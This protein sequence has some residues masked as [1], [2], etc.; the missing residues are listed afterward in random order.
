[1]KIHSVTLENIKSIYDRITI[2]FWN[3]LN[4]FIWPNWSWKSN[5][6]DTLNN[7]IHHHFIYSYIEQ[8]NSH[9]SSTQLNKQQ[10]P[11][12]LPKNNKRNNEN[13]YRCVELQLDQEDLTNIENIKQNIDLLIEIEKELTKSQSSDLTTLKNNLNEFDPVIWL[14]KHSYSIDEI[15]TLDQ[16]RS[17]D[18]NVKT[19]KAILNY[20]RY[21]EKI[22][23]LI[24]K[25]NQKN[26]VQKINPLYIPFKFYSPN[27][28]HEWH[29]FNITTVNQNLTQKQFDTKV[30]S[31]Q[32]TSSDIDYSI[33]FFASLFNKLNRNE[34]EFYNQ[35]IV[36]ETNKILQS[37]WSYTFGVKT[38][39]VNDNKYTIQ[40][41]H[42]DWI[43]NFQSMSSWEKELLNL[44]FSIMSLDIKNAI[45]NIDEPEV[46]LHPQ[47]QVKL[48]KLYTELSKSRGIQFIIITHS[49]VLVTKDTIKNIIRVYKDKN[50]TNIH[51]KEK[52]ESRNKFIDGNKNLI[53]IISLA[54]NAKV[55]FADKVILVEWITD[56]IIFQYLLNIYNKKDQN[57]E[58]IAVWSKD[59]FI[60]YVQFLNKFNISS[61]IIGDKDNIYRWNLLSKED[62]VKT[63]R[64]KIGAAKRTKLH[65]PKLV[66]KN[67]YENLSQKQQVSK[68][69]S[70]L[71]K[72]ALNDGITDDEK[73]YIHFL[74]NRS[75]DSS[76]LQTESDDLKIKA[77]ILKWYK[78]L[79]IQ[80]IKKKVKT[81]I[82]SYWVI[83]SYWNEIGHNK[84]WAEKLITQIKDYLSNYSSSQTRNEKI[85][86]LKQIVQSCLK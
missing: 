6:V 54:N 16:T 52:N 11:L 24:E 18:S 27:R 1:M 23:R 80:W 4:I 10:A 57:I 55:F 61:C 84:I 76:W 12:S 34:S 62:V 13:Q 72:Q 78:W 41:K 19:S 14:K 35:P 7:L 74:I 70:I 47:W 49:P 46:H 69:L 3:W 73:E 48:I 60:E 29:S 15:N 66:K 32:N 85:E 82:L 59:R 5:I 63:L 58:I 8:Y 20:L 50:G 51:P 67:A 2:N 36:Q 40:I 64:T 68:I 43:T 22:K 9:N 81:F 75:I 38:V 77:A 86:E 28:F 65:D 21:F 33:L 17:D 56:E 44:V 79:K 83:E 25:Y 53:D 37:I 30:K 31:S 39:N 26:G 42:K 45:I 71:H